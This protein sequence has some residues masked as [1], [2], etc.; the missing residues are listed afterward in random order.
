MDAS[1]Q[2][3]YEDMER[4]VEQLTAELQA[5]NERLERENA[6]RVQAEEALRESKEWNRLLLGSISD[7]CWV[8]DKEWRYR[9]VNEAG[10]RLVNMSPG[11]LL[12][13]KLTT[14]FPGIED[15]EFFAAYERAMEEQSLQVVTGPFTHPDRGKGIY[16]VRVYPVPDG[17]LCIGRNI[18]EQVQAADA[19]GE[20]EEK[21]RV[22]FETMAQGVVYQDA[23][24]KITS[25]NPAAERILGLTLDQM[26]GRSSIDPRWRAIHEDGSD[27]PG[28]THPAMVALRTGQAVRDVVMGVFHPQEGKHRWININ[29]VPQFKPGADKPYQ[30]YATF[31]DITGRVQAEA[32][33]RKLNAELEGRVAERTHQLETAY[34][35]LEA[36]AYSLSHDLRSP[37]RGIKGFPQILLQDYAPQLPAEAQDYLERVSNAAQRM[38][39]LIDGLLAFLR[40]GRHPLEK[41]VVSPAELVRKALDDLQ[42]ELAGRDVDVTVDDLPTCR[43][44]P[45][46]LEQVF[47]HLLSNALKYTRQRERARIKV[48]WEHRDD[49]TVYRVQDN[50][51]GFDMKYAPKVFGMFQQLHPIGEYEG[52]GIGLA[53]VQRIVHRHGGEAWVEA[54][55]GQGATFFFTL[56][57]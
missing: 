40:L 1:L 53:L 54:Q 4:L 9:L 38:N 43:A 5:A 19:L 47:A 37:L 46:L 28:E 18:T 34:K 11:Q 27:F 49:Q 31:N 52:T 45:V 44:D 13:Q 21:Y 6:E 26:Q 23:D 24:G 57:E 51:V 33:I 48:D 10:A 8:L 16:N 30:V 25:A 22:L 42:D 14:L 55:E 17:I 7:G 12:G 15:T 50:G 29:A 3:A 32:K 56:G 2:H 35:E 20:S 36:A 41:K 39:E